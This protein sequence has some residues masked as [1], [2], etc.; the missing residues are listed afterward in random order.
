MQ[1]L[2]DIDEIMFLCSPIIN[3]INELPDLGLYLNDLNQHGLSKEMVLA[4]WHHN[5][6]LELMF[7][8]AEQRA[9]ELESNYA[10]LDTWKRRGDELLYTM[11]PKTVADRLR[12]GSNPLST[13]ETFDSVTIMFCQLVGFNQ[14]TVEDAMGLVST[15]NAVFSCF[16]SLMDKFD[17]KVY[18]V[19]TVGEVYMA[20]SGAPEKCKEHASHI[21]HVSLSMIEHIEQL[22]IPFSTEVGVRIGVHSGPAVAG[23]VGI[24]VPR[25]CFFGDTVNT[26]SR[27]QSTSQRGMVHISATTKSLLPAGMFRFQSRGTVK[28]K[29]KGEMETYW[30]T[31]A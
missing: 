29:G 12:S 19:E 25:Y 5:S 16:D 10:L 24:K 6:K 22:E 8:K 14:S 26:A 23:C 28:I 13:C 30:L 17:N 20:V 7:D 21:S 27:M 31:A 15:M 1:Y 11:I 9:T 18:K 2:E 4:G 3:D